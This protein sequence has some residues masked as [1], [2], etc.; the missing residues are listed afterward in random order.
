MTLDEG[1]GTNRG[2]CGGNQ[3]D[4]AGTCGIVLRGKLTSCIAPGGEVAEVV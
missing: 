2:R 1:G 4:G 3:K